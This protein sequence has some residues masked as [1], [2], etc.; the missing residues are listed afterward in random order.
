[1]LKLNYFLWQNA[2]FLNLDFEKNT[3][4]LGKCTLNKW[5]FLN[6]TKTTLTG[7]FSHTL[8]STGSIRRVF[9]AKLLKVTIAK[10]NLTYYNVGALDFFCKNNK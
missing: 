1:M 9:V 8:L 6:E 7:T 2:L 4:I 3:N 10:K 5:L